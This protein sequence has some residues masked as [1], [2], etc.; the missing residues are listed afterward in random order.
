MSIDFAE[1]TA[2]L[3]K[4]KNSRKQKK[5]EANI[6]E[7]GKQLEKLKKTMD[8]EIQG[9]SNQLNKELFILQKTEKQNAENLN[10]ILPEIDSYNTELNSV[11]SR[12]NEVPVIKDQLVRFSQFSQ[13]STKTFSDIKDTL[14][15]LNDS[16]ITDTEF[17]AIVGDIETK[18]EKYK[19][20]LTKRINSISTGGNANRNIA[21]GGT[22]TALSR[23][24]DINL[25]AGSNV[26]I[27][28][29]N[30]DTTKYTDVTISSSGGSGSTRSINSIST[31]QEAGNVA[32][33][34]YVYLC[35]DTLTLTMPT[36]VGNTNL[37][38]IKNIGSGIITI[39]TTG[40]ETIDGSST[41]VMPVQFTAVDLISNNT[42]DWAIT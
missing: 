8:E 14:Q 7:L 36:T 12:L 27:S 28:Y 42:G 35:S 26:T 41:L 38:T 17:T 39:N 5:Q 10:A 2:K 13:E 31:S 23:Y 30:N 34:D 1:F 16:K 11:K 4:I 29:Q 15:E 22:L 3:E 37:Y 32:G 25:K 20:E 9:V 18:I 40:G 6:A 19:T 21:I 33:T 24:T